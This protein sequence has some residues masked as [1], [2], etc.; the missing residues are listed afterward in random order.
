MRPDKD[1]LVHSRVMYQG[2][3]MV[4]TS[5][6]LMDID[7]LILR[8]ARERRRM[9]PVRRDWEGAPAGAHV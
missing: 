9:T 7:M 5:R 1:T 8:R 4:M 6:V 3:S 2:G